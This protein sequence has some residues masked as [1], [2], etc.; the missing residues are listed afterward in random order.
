MSNAVVH[1][2]RDRIFVWISKPTNDA[3]DNTEV[4]NIVDLLD[5]GWYKKGYSNQNEYDKKLKRDFKV[6]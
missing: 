5:N 2:C 6:N 4:N 3:K 1:S